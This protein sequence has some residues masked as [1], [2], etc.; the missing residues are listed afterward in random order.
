MFLK[1][2][3]NISKDTGKVYLYYR[4]ME[5]YRTPKGPRH[6]KIL[7][8]GKLDI[9]EHLHKPLADRIEE[10]VKGNQN[11]FS[12]QIDPEI[13]SLA[14]HYAQLIIK[15]NL[16]A[17]DLAST[18]QPSVRIAVESELADYDEIDLN[19]ISNGSVRTIGVEHLGVSI[20]KELK[21]DSYLKEL[22]LSDTQVNDAI[23]A[24]VGRLAIAS[25]ESAT[26]SWARNLSGIDE[27]LGT[28]YSKLPN[29][30]LYRTSDILYSH[31]NNLEQYLRQKAKDLFSL[32]DNIILYDLTNTF[33]EGH[34]QNNSKIDYGRSKEKRFD[35]P[36]IT[37][38][39]MV[40]QLGFAKKTEIFSGSVSEP[41]TL[42]IM[43]KSL[44]EKGDTI[45][46]LEELAE[47]KPTTVKKNVTVIMDAGIAT[48]DNLT[49]L[50]LNGFDYICVSRE[51]LKA[52]HADLDNDGLITIRET[53]KS[54]IEATLVK[55]S[56]QEN[57]LC[58]RSLEKQF[59][60]N[61]MK[62]LFQ[63][64]FEEALRAANDALS[65]KRSLK[66][67]EKVLEKIG[68]LR[69]KYSAIS[70]F[71]SIEVL[72]G[73]NNL[74]TAITWELKD[75]DAI[76]LRFSGMYYLR[77]SRTDLNEKEIWDLYNTIRKVESSFRSLKS[78]LKMRP[79][80][81]QNENRIDGHIFITVLAYH[82]LNIIQTRLNAQNIHLE[83]STIK[84]MMSTRVRVSTSMKNRQGQKIIIR[85][86]TEPEPFH[87]DIYNALGISMNPLKR[88]KSM[89][90]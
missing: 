73:D 66:K 79:N 25:S 39:L 52:E 90:V 23:L 45:F 59:K 80:F 44:H 29:N 87:I 33:F 31:K 67:Y 89:L 57:V 9:P 58:C 1:K 22:G 63:L 35:C 86:T 17:N 26:R 38:G 12:A 68:R 18:A 84:R 72:K 41:K 19:S 54:H 28:D 78:E 32:N 36:L 60:E 15:K 46:S 61:S 71:Y 64:R 7:E 6:R 88:N 14:Q 8:L 30:N 21:L 47:K 24:I 13:E 50:R 20:I 65:K 51:K 83:W 85:N 34:P 49:L 55:M 70:H 74:A 77:T 10:I 16:A 76:N 2:I 11:L 62:T 40:D 56:D 42:Y 43:L 27:L 3:E 82:I 4:L 69:E 53:P 81:H 48:K 5:S 75:V 37:L